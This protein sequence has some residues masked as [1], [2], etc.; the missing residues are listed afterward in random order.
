MLDILEEEM[1]AT[2]QSQMIYAVASRSV[3]INI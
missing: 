2:T 1:K 3:L